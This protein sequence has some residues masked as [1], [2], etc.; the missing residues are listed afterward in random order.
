MRGGCAGFLHLICTPGGGVR[1]LETEVSSTYIRRDDPPFSCIS[2]SSWLTE[3]RE[4]G[5]ECLW[6]FFA[7]NE[8]EEEVEGKEVP[9][10]RGGGEK[11]RRSAS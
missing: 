10:E 11:R 6:S 1:T 8:G 5:V 7:E 4:K 2:P 3:L 9:L